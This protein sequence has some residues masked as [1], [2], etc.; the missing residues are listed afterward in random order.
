MS[1]FKVILQRMHCLSYVNCY[2]WLHFFPQTEIDVNCQ[3]VY[4]LVPYQITAAFVSSKL[5]AVN[6][7]LLRVDEI[8]K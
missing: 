7:T 1:Y 4:I 3:K 5:M 8:T 2:Q 6:F